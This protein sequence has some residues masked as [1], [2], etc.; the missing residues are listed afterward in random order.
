MNYVGLDVHKEYCQAAILNE[1]GELVEEKRIQTSEQ[2]FKQLA[3]AIDKGSSIVM[4]A[5]CS[6]Y[7]PHDYFSGRGYDVRVAH[8]KNVKAIASSKVKTDK[9]DAKI[10][11]DLL[12]AN[13]IPEIYVPDRGIRQL[14]DLLTH[15]QGLV[16]MRTEAKNRIHAV[17]TKRGIRHEFSDLF[18]K[19]GWVWLKSL[20]LDT[21]GR[22]ELRQGMETIK[23]LDAQITKVEREIYAYEKS[24]PETRLLQTMPG[25]GRLISMIMLAEIADANRFPDGKKLASYA[26]LTP[27]VHQSGDI[28]RHGRITKQGSKMLRTAMIQATQRAMHR[29]TK[30]RRFYLRVSKR[31][32]ENKAK[33]AV[34]RKMLGWSF[35]MLK[36]GEPF[37]D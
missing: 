25:I 8:P 24:F 17:L 27:S 9:I 30:I 14:R 36:R 12:R 29:D 2:G 26:G 19:A 23:L 7:T 3:R 13:L 28:D 33:V 5:S 35:I 15:R 6:F 32:G 1:Q 22:L 4:E 18:G 37:A 31:H 34:A 16:K 11:A 10:L 21:S 20:E